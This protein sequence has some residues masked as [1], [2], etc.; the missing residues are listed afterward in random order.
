MS[1]TLRRWSKKPPSHFGSGSK[2]GWFCIDDEVRQMVKS[3]L[4]STGQETSFVNNNIFERYITVLEDRGILEADD[5]WLESLILTDKTG[6]GTNPNQRK[7]FFKTGAKNAYLQISNETR[8]MYTVLICGSAEGKSLA[9]LVV[10][11]GK[12]LYNTR[13]ENGPENTF[14]ACEESGWLEDTVFQKWFTTVFIKHLNEN[15]I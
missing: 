5:A 4:D 13:T 7:L 2:M 10:Y 8:S 12:N 3:F 14:Y 11:K 1:Q 9:P 15:N 6:M